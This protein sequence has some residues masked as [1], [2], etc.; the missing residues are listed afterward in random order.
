MATAS[1]FLDNSEL[2]GQSE[3]AGYIG[4]VV[5]NSVS[6]GASNDTDLH[7]GNTKNANTYI[8]NIDCT[9]VVDSATPSIARKCVGGT[10]LPTVTITITRSMGGDTKRT[11]AFTVITLTNVVVTN[12]QVHMTD[13][14][15]TE[16]FTLHYT[17]IGVKVTPQDSKGNALAEAT[18]TYDIQEGESSGT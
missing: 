4:Q 3:T 6:F 11:Y 18:W 8:L 14:D 10:H 16:T 7:S 9:K 5:L 12:H 15:A 2:K 17:K 1:I 13:G